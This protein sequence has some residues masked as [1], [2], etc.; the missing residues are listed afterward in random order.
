[1]SL[2]IKE[3]I[4]K[5]IVSDYLEYYST[6]DLAIK[7]NFHRVT[8][9]RILKTYNIPLRKRTAAFHDIHFF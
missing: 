9:Q 8:I 3:E 1:M 4:E 5:A 2:R 7:Y 6:S